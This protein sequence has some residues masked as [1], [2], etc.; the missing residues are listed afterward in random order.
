MSQSSHKMYSNNIVNFQESMAI[1]NACTK[2][3]GNL[4]HVQRMSC[5]SVNLEKI[6]NK[7]KLVLLLRSLSSYVTGSFCVVIFYG[8]STSE[9]H[10]MLTEVM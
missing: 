2:K 6:R 9:G 4:L 3:S 5:V 7:K 1:I 10:L 8:I